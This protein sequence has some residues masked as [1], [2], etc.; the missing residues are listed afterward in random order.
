MFTL[1]KE[2]NIFKLESFENIVA[3]EEIAPAGSFSFFV[4]MFSML[5][6]TA[7]IKTSIYG[8]KG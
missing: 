4:T 5:S 7:D 3:K 8:V 1:L 6:A 2:M